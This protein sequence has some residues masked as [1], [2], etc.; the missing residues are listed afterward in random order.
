MRRV[1]AS[2]ACLGLLVMGCGGNEQGDAAATVTTYLSA[3]ADGDGAEACDQLTGQAKRE[4]TAGIVE[5]VPELQ[6]DFSCDGA[7]EAL[8]DLLGEDERSV[9]REAEVAASVDGDE[10]TASLE[11]SPNEVELRRVDGRWLISGGFTF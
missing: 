1:G 6:S 2:V 10:A 4:L 11:G 8:A 9:L 3:L 7:V 5:T